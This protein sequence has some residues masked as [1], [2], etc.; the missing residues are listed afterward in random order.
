MS[1]SLHSST[2]NFGSPK[3]CLP[4]STA[5]VCVKSSMGEMSLNISARPSSRN[6]SN[7]SFWMAMR[8]GT[9]STSGILAKF[10]RLRFPSS[11]TDKNIPPVVKIRQIVLQTCSSSY[12]THSIMQTLIVP[13][14]YTH[15]RAHETRHDLVCRLLLEK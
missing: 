3:K 4:N 9:G 13:V 10:R 1:F 14:S 15:L 7:D 12:P 6:H 2:V 11:A 5:M 8:S